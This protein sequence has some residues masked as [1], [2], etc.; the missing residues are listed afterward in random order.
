MGPRQPDLH[1]PVPRQGRQEAGHAVPRCDGE[2]G[3][4]A[5]FKRSGVDPET[6]RRYPLIDKKEGS[7]TFIR[8]C[9][10]MCEE[11]PS[12]TMFSVSRGLLGKEKVGP[13]TQC[14]LFK[15]SVAEFNKDAG[16]PVAPMDKEAIKNLLKTDGKGWTCQQ[17]ASVF[18][19]HKTG[20]FADA[21]AGFECKGA[22]K[23]GV[24]DSKKCKNAFCKGDVGTCC[25][26]AADVCY[27]KT[28]LLLAH[29]RKM[30]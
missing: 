25:V 12:C 5:G 6:G 1:H 28:P 7:H 19:H 17:G 29:Q 4:L 30:A 9:R 11:F 24:S 21:D 22:D 27:R 23:L 14:K 26:Q 8:W 3:R 18:R 10:Q 15:D 2:Y 20:K 16:G 13:G